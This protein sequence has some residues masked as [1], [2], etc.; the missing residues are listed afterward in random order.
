MAFSGSVDFLFWSLSLL[1][2]LSCWKYNLVSVTMLGNSN[3]HFSGKHLAQSIWLSPGSVLLFSPLPT[4]PLRGFAV[5]WEAT[6]MDKTRSVRV[7]LSFSEPLSSFL[8]WNDAVYQRWNSG[9]P[10]CC[11]PASSLSVASSF[12]GGE[13]REKKLQ[14]PSGLKFPFE[15]MAINIIYKMLYVGL[16]TRGSSCDM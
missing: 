6:L 1:F 12:K 8:T 4:C 10:P 5:E 13:R 2:L 11:V 7:L 3:Q 15:N 16:F 9:H 14:L